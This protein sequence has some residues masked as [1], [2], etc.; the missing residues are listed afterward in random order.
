VD[1]R[2]RSEV[3]GQA[4]AEGHALGE[5]DPAV[6]R[7]GF[8]GELHADGGQRDAGEDQQV[9]GAPHERAQR[10]L[11]AGGRLHAPEVDPP[12]AGGEHEAEDRGEC[13][14]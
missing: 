3:R 2:H 14:R 4:A 5:L 13:R 7:L 8:D 11:A 9:P 1:G 6:A 12:H 10:A